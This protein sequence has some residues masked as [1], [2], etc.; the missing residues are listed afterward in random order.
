MRLGSEFGLTS[1]CLARICI[2][3]STGK[4]QQ[5]SS[6]DNALTLN[7]GL[8]LAQQQLAAFGVIPKTFEFT[9]FQPG[10]YVGQVLA[11]SMSTPTGPGGAAAIINTSWFIREINA[12]LV[13]VFDAN[14][15]ENTAFLPGSGHYRYTVQTI[16]VSQIGDWLDFWEGL[17]GGGGSAS[18][19][20]L[21]P[22]G[23]SLGPS[24]TSNGYTQGFTAV[25]DTPLAITHGL[26]TTA[27]IVQAYDSGG[28]SV[29]FSGLVVTSAN[30]VTVAFGIGFSGTIVIL[31]VG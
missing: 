4:Y 30:V 13:P 9:T 28:V 15:E 5:T 23:G 10:L 7:E 18:G 31:G 20:A 6:D 1:V 22:G 12:E 14:D 17:S 27:V 25:A 29:A 24:G 11:I 26:N 2:E 3:A 19:T 21:F 16:N 8:Q